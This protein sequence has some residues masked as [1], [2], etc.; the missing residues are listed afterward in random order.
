MYS[1]CI[2]RSL[3]SPG[4]I[5]VLTTP[6]RVVSSGAFMKEAGVHP[7]KV[8]QPIFCVAGG[9]TMDHIQKNLD[10][11]GVCSINQILQIIRSAEVAEGKENTRF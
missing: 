3:G 11:H 7:V 5:H 4:V 9:V 10:V 8:V 1:A 2:F 6:E